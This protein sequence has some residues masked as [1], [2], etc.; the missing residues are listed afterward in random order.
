[1]T[2]RAPFAPAPIEEVVAQ[3]HDE[4]PTLCLP[5]MSKPLPE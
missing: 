2:A 4:S 1:M 3:I 5:R